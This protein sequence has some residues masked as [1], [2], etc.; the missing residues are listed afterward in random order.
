MIFFLS[1]KIIFII[2]QPARLRAL[3]LY[4][5]SFAPVRPITFAYKALKRPDLA[6]GFG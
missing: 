2:I 5:Q 3:L 6:A 4:A 1:H